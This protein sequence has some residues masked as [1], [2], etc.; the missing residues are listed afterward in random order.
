MNIGLMNTSTPSNSLVVND[1]YTA[2]LKFSPHVFEDSYGQRIKGL[3]ARLIIT[4]IS[5]HQPV[6]ETACSP[7]MPGSGVIVGTVKVP[8]DAS[9]GVLNL[10]NIEALCYPGKHMSINVSSSVV[11]GRFFA[12]K[13]TFQVNFRPCVAGEYLKDY[14]CVVCPPGS[15]SLQQNPGDWTL[16]QCLP[17][18]KNAICRDGTIDTSPGY[19][20]S[21]YF[22]ATLQKCPIQQ[23]CKGGTLKLQRSAKAPMYSYTFTYAYAYPVDYTSLVQDQCAVGYT[24]PLCGVCSPGY[25]SIDN[26]CKACVSSGDSSMSAVI[27]VPSVIII[28][29]IAILLY[30][31]CSS[32]S[33]K[34]EQGHEHHDED[35][36]DKT[37]SHGIQ[38]VDH[39]NAPHKQRI[40]S[41]NGQ[42][43]GRALSSN[44]EIVVVATASSLKDRFNDIFPFF[45]PIMKIVLT[46]SHISP[47]R[48]SLCFDI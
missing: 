19:W 31:R 22:S 46:L 16:T 1:Y 11:P 4:S 42:S 9:T 28:V 13:D 37:S 18:P 6:N 38:M 8:S 40:G 34:R 36:L 41:Q 15:Y 21:N 35:A 25:Y 39:Y 10:T 48:C 29:G 30:L 27:V 26:E 5:I 43:T 20:R 14:A 33:S 2:P 45:V 44:L 47:P 32:K 24:G 23:A 17:C 3:L 7:R 12:I